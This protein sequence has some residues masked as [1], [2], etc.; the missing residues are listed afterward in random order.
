MDNKEETLEERTY[1][2]S[3]L[4]VMH[5]L[6]GIAAVAYSV[7]LVMNYRG[8]VLLGSLMTFGILFYYLWSMYTSISCYEEGSVSTARGIFAA[9]G[10]LFLVFFVNIAVCASS[11]GIG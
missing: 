8:N 7:F 10:G 4:S 6:F 11:V 1:R 9:V 5:F 2:G 3:L